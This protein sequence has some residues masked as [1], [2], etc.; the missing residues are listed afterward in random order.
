MDFHMRMIKIKHEINHLNRS[1]TMNTGT[2]IKH[3]PT[4]QAHNQMNH[5]KIPSDLK[6]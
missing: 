2:I 3:L 6:N 5:C 1:I 4:K